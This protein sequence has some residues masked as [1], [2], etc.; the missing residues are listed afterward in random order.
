MPSVG[1]IQRH[2]P[3]L[4]SCTLHGQVRMLIMNSFIDCSEEVKIFCLSRCQAVPPAADAFP[5]DSGYVCA[6]TNLNRAVQV[7]M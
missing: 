6:V 5:V 4:Q 2:A 7:P 3:Q 1:S